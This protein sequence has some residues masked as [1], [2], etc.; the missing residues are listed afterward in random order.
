[1]TDVARGVA[2]VV[3]LSGGELVG[4]T[5]L[6]K[7]VYFLEARHVGY[8]FDFSYHYYGPYS[9]ELSDAS[10][11]ASALNYI[12]F[13]WKAGRHPFAVYQSKIEMKPDGLAERRKRILDVLSKYDSV[14][15]ELAATADYL[16]SAGFDEDPW[17]EVRRRKGDKVTEARIGKANELLQAV[18]ATLT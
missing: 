9:E 12:S 6:Q 11:D 8:G 16:K 1:M 7:S 18:D 15:L 17:I 14:V 10:T 13:D 3:A 2:E 4:K 5:R